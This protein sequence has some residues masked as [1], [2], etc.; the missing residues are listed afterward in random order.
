MTTRSR[1]ARA[2]AAVAAVNA[3]TVAD[4]AIR[5]RNAA[6]ERGNDANIQN[7][8]LFDPEVIRLCMDFHLANVAAD[9]A[10]AAAA[11]AAAAA[12]AAD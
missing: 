8:S 11:T 10:I 7:R 4:E 6:V 9:A 2:A 1:T 5:L 3:R 12:A